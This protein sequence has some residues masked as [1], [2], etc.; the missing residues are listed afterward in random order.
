MA[1]RRKS[2]QPIGVGLTAKQSKRKKPISLDYLVDIDP[3]TENQIKLFAFFI[4]H[5]KMFLT[6]PLLMKRFI[7][8]VL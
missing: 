6:K 5:L 3:L 2:D 8:F 4:R 1:R 7:L